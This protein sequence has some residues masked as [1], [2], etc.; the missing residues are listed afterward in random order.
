[1]T[2]VKGVRET[3]ERRKYVQPV[4]VDLRSSVLSGDH[5]GYVHQEDPGPSHL[6]I[7]PRLPRPPPLGRVDHFNDLNSLFLP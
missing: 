3:R 5:I 7:S 1:M 2:E 6:L 4:L